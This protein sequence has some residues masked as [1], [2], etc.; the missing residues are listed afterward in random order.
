M[1]SEV[2]SFFSFEFLYKR[3]INE[4]FLHNT[5]FYP[6]LSLL[7]LFQI[8]PRAF[9]PSQLKN[10]GVLFTVDESPTMS[11]VAVFCRPEPE[12]CPR[13]MLDSFCF[14]LG[15]LCEVS[16]RELSTF[17][18]LPKRKSDIVLFLPI[19]LF[20]STSALLHII[21]FWIKRYQRRWWTLWNERWGLKLLIEMRKSGG[22]TLIWHYS[23]YYLSCWGS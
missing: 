8:C 18:L 14:L 16:A 12:P 22:M 23:V 4:L 3:G 20:N 15:G 11:L 17:L 6:W 1:Q 7:L 5:F 2:K 19:H 21:S 13:C 10:P 9:T